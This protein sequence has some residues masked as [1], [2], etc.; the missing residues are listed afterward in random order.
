MSTKIE[1]ARHPALPLFLFLRTLSHIVVIL[2]DKS[3]VL[4]AP[5]FLITPP[6]TQLNTP[7]PATAYLKGFLNTK[8]IAAR[9]ADLG[10]EVTL[11]LFSKTGL[12]ELFA[13]IGSQPQNPSP[14]AEP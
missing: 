10:I 3:A 1:R 12:Q 7:Y 14:N 9:Q 8:N 6:F 13:H 5:V 11:A 4:Q 2:Q